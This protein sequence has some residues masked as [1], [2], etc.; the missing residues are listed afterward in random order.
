[1]REL[2]DAFN[3]HHAEN[4][5]P[6]WLSCLDESIN[7]QLNKNCPGF[8]IVERKP[9]PS[10]NKYHSIAYGDDG[11]PIMWRIKLQE[12]KDRPKKA[13]GTWAFPSQF[14]SESKTV[15]LMLE[16]TEPIH[17]TGMIV[18]M[19]SAFC[20]SA[21]ILA[22][23]DKGVYDQALIK[24][25]GWYWLRGVPGDEINHFEGKQIGDFECFVQEKD[26][27]QFLIHCH[28]EDKYVCKVMSMHGR[29]EET[30]R[31][32]WRI[33][34]DGWS[35][36]KYT[37]AITNHCIAK[38]WVDDV[39]NRRHAPI[40]LDDIWAT[41]W[42]PHRQFTFMCSVA[43]VNANNS[44]ARAMGAPAVH[45]IVFRKQL[46]KEMMYNKLTETGGIRHSPIRARKR[47]R[48]SLGMEHKL[49]EADVH[50]GLGSNRQKLQESKHR[51]YEAKKLF[52]LQED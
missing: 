10:G 18:T 52:M 1:M 32:A 36:F 31:E 12:G 41:N 3:A 5:S 14:E 28:K 30:D 2:Q 45:Q 8:M 29:I 50:W 13:D 51:V 11:K 7:T 25:R 44:L 40:G 4:Y 17:G 19:D 34:K 38:H 27:K 48:E 35:S 24:K 9:Y 46:A 22:L 6:S 49:D 16:M 15:K 39:N 21:G 23:H 33:G 43:E 42:W 26:D 47:S 20:V 37:D